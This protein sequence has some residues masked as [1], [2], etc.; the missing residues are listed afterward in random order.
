MASSTRPLAMVTGAS[1]G[2]GFELAKKCA[3]NGYDLVIA[4][5]QSD[6][7]EA[8]DR[9]RLL[10]VDVETVEADLA[11]LEGVDKLYGAAR[12]LPIDLLIANAGHGLR[13]AF[14]DQDF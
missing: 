7:S 2:I 12:G 5:D 14:L 13:H 11:T 10:G 9:L 3:E 1:S 4:A 6:L 8:A